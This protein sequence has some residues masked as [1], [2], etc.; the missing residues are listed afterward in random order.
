MSW[1][2]S[3]VCYLRLDFSPP[4]ENH[5]SICQVIAHR[6]SIPISVIAHGP[7]SPCT[8]RSRKKKIIRGFNY[9][10]KMPKGSSSSCVL[11]FSSM[12][13]VRINQKAASCRAVYSLPSSLQWLLCQSRIFNLTHS[14]SLHTF[15]RKSITYNSTPIIRLTHPI[16]IFSLHL[17]PILHGA[18]PSW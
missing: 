11:V 16:L 13:A 5:T 3:M 12:I 1:R 6:E 18:M 7:S 2:A 10:R 9:G 15:S 14:I 8:Q 4:H 17:W